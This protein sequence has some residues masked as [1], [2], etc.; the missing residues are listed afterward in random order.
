MSMSV[1]DILSKCSGQTITQ[2]FYYLIDKIKIL[3]DMNEIL[4]KL[5]IAMIQCQIALFIYR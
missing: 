3:D 4:N 5:K 2:S 1:I